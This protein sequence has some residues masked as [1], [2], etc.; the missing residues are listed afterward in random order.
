MA[1]KGKPEQRRGTKVLAKKGVKRTEVKKH[2]VTEEEM[3]PRVAIP[4]KT[5]GLVLKGKAQVIERDTPPD[6]EAPPMRSLTQ[7]QMA[8]EERERGGVAAELSRRG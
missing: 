2:A 8:R 1:Q 4:K 5:K 6:H 7:K 3:S